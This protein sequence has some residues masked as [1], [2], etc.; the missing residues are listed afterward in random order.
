VPAQVKIVAA[1]HGQIDLD[2]VLGL[3]SASKRASMSG[4][5]TTSMAKAEHHHDAHDH[6]AFDSVVIELPE[7]DGMPCWRAWPTSWPRTRSTASRALCPWRASPCAWWC[8]AWASALTAI[9]TAAGATTRA[10]THLVFIGHDLEEDRIRAALNG[11]T[12]GAL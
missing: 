1:E 10:Q 6:D 4:W 8:M 2:V 9:S 11:L 3:S 5:A 7:V 12:A